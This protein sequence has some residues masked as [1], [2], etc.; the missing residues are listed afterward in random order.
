M[1]TSV[2]QAGHRTAT[3]FD[4]RRTTRS[5]GTPSTL[6]LDTHFP[7]GPRRAGHGE[8]A[9]VLRP[10]GDGIGATTLTLLLRARGGRG[11]GICAR[12]SG[13]TKG[14]DV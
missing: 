12:S 7:T 10:P 4:F 6:L 5:A 1:C 2:T 3:R 8:D 9:G 14:R 13:G 11:G